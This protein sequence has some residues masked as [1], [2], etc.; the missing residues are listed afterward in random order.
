ME[1]LL[2]LLIPV[3]IFGYPFFA[4]VIAN[5]GLKHRIAE[6]EAQVNKLNMALMRGDVRGDPTADVAARPAD[7]ATQAP[8]QAA[9]Y[10]PSPPPPFRP[11]PAEP[12]VII[13]PQPAATISVPV[14]TATPPAAVVPPASPEPLPV[15]VTPTPSSPV[16]VAAVPPA[17]PRPAPTFKA[18]RPPPA[19][20][21]AAK[22]W[23]FTGNL[24]AK[25]GLLILFIGVSFLL[26][27][28][29]ERVTVPI[30]LRLAGI[31]LAD[32]GLLVW[33]WRMRLT[34][35]N[36][37]LPIQGAALA[38]LMLVTFGAFRLYH[39][40]PS[41]LAFG[42]LFVLTIFTCLLA[43]LQNAV[44]LA[45][46]GIS[47]GFLSPI[48]TSTGSGSHVA[49]FSYYTLLNAGVLA[50]ALKRTWRALNLLGFAF[51]FVIGTAWGVLRYSA[52]TDFLS[53]Q[54]FLILFFLFYVAIAVVYAKRRM[55]EDKP[56][57]D[58]TIVFGTAMAAFALQL[59]LM[60]NFEFG[61]AFSALVF[62]LFY[63]VLSMALWK[64]RSGNLKLL[65]ES[66]VA[67][68]V[69]FGTLAIP[70]AL[71]GRWTSA[72]WALE[73]A[74]VAWI[75]LRQRQRLA[76]MFGQLVQAGA[77]LS[78]L[79]SV[80]GL[81]PQAAKDSNLWLGFL[82]LAASAFFMATTLRKHQDDE[83][84][85]FP[86]A[87]SWFLGF[88][89]I[90]FM[91][92]AWTEILLRQHGTTQANML[93][94]S[95]LATA[96]ILAGIAARMQWQR[97]RSF[98]W[99]AQMIAG[100]ALFIIVLGNWR[101]SRPTYEL[102]DQPFIG[103]VMIF[104]AALFTSLRMARTPDV[105]A[106]AGLARPMLAWAALWWFGPILHALSGSL[107]LA[108]LQHR[109][110]WPS[111][112][113]LC[114]AASAI[115]FALLARRLQWTD[116][117]W[118]SASAWP[119][120]TLASL[121]TLAELYVGDDMPTAAIWI[122]FG[123][124]WLASEYLLRFWPANGW[125]LNDI[126][127]RVIHT[128]RTAAPWIMLWK[129]CEIAIS[130]W[131]TEGGVAASGSWANFVPAW[132]MMAVVMWLI[133]RSEKEQWPV[134]PVA[135]W[136]RHALLPVATAWSLLLA[137]VWNLLQDGG[138]TPLPYIP[139]LNPLD[140]TTAFAFLLAVA[141]YRMLKA[142]TPEF[143]A[144]RQTLVRRL[145]MAGAV[146]AYIWFNLILLRT[147]SHLLDIPYS[148]DDLF[149]SLFVQAMLS[150]VWSVTALVLMWRAAKKNS[151]PQWMIGAGFLALV[152]A[153]LFL[154]DLDGVGSVARIVSFVGVGLLM[155]LIGY[156]APYPNA[157]E[158]AEAKTGE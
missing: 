98:A 104:A 26:K 157:G 103:A 112:Y 76:F 128:I 82:I 90:W 3:F 116:L 39:L 119:A 120:M 74:G 35:R 146:G 95:G 60:R 52:D 58:A 88:A 70:F 36:L 19:W 56:Y 4:A 33:G 129:A 156:L 31:V 8:V 9:P 158:P 37:S 29:S 118:M 100:A 6:L 125:T 51:T 25:M 149:A 113:C 77:W 47:G 83:K 108:T 42:L 81:G 85:A 87:A 55:V 143:G 21:V 122:S 134:A 153:K 99:A 13:V 59:G 18:P 111:M 32:I 150:L 7:A 94:A 136:Y 28:A 23:L 11:K 75:G 50:I 41:G 102:F 57:V 137:L 138:M 72:A 10:A 127:L 2:F 91:A 89:G 20:L 126:A 63:M 84:Q 110:E 14:E 97:A 53:A 73:G 62:G 140:L 68:G 133:A 46:F 115:G 48:M 106:A 132:T 78:F 54:L 12:A 49:L 93:V 144:A 24:V 135:S 154:V 22:N 40:I 65:V 124:A 64:R 155:V 16:Q 121:L 17:A 109:A 148:A 79:G 123:G 34:H 96:G 67:L 151:R 69:V 45:V 92:G 152:V 15:V 80:T 5:R 66:F 61:N 130:S 43:V 101:W 105:K 147:A 142:D 141:C 86:H 44:W 1:V 117:R 139:L 71:D 27:Y 114:A 38:I 107:V 145:P 131:L 30:E